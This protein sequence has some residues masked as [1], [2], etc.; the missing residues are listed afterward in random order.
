MEWLPAPAGWD[1]AI[2]DYDMPEMNG[3]QLAS[4]IRNWWPHLPIILCTAL[5]EAEMTVPAGLFDDRGGH[6]L[7]DAQ[8]QALSLPACLTICAVSSVCS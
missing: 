5:H 2:L 1:A 8:Q 3:E 6:C 4:H 7:V